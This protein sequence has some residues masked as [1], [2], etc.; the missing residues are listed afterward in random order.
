MTKR[1]ITIWITIM[2]VSVTFLFYWLAVLREGEEENR[3]I[4]IPVRLGVVV[5][6]G[7]NFR[8]YFYAQIFSLD[9][10]GVIDTSVRPQ[11]LSELDAIVFLVDEWPDIVDYPG[12]E[13]FRDSFSQVAQNE[14]G[15]YRDVYLVELNYTRTIVL[16][17]A[18]LRNNS[19]VSCVARDLIM[20]LADG[21]GDFADTCI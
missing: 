20:S 2:A 16:F 8:D 19:E 14:L 5:S 10:L 6:Q 3:V 7:A 21:V 18:K 13:L 17:F 15:I 12:S 11:L 1:N 4:S 9:G